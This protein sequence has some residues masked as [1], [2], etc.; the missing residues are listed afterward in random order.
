MFERYTEKAR[1]VIFFARY[2]AR[3]YGS[4]TIE[5]EHLLLGVVRE[6]PDSVRRLLD[7]SE[8]ESRIRQE[9]EKH[10]TI[11]DRV[12]TT[13]EVPLSTDSKKILNFAAEEAERAGQRYIGPEYLLLGVLRVENCLA[14]ETLRSLGVTLESAREKIAKIKISDITVKT[15]RVA[16]TRDVL[17]SFL[18]ALKQ[19][20]AAEIAPFFAE[21]ALLIDSRGHT[22]I[23]RDNIDFQSCFAPFATKN[24]RAHVERAERGLSD[25]FVAIIFWE[26]VTIAAGA[27]R[28]MHRMTIVFGREDGAW[29]IFV[30]QVTPVATR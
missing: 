8:I 22:W 26:D 21:E 25:T 12:F 7:E 14:A 28:S 29:S 27:A 13:V 18:S 5:T 3:Q 24:A 20:R 30:L 10:I 11:R 16:T 15:D 1:R 19:F 2:E 17:D 23:G 9:I 6:V 4:P